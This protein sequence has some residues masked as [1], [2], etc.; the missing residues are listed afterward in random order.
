MSTAE[1]TGIKKTALGSRETYNNINMHTGAC[2]ATV[3]FHVNARA[4][5][6]F[7]LQHDFYVEVEARWR[8]RKSDRGLPYGSQNILGTEGEIDAYVL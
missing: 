8:S 6:F 5:H 3:L 2:V 4:T 1:S 7:K